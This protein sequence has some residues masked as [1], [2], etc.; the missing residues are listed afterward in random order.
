MLPVEGFSAYMALSLEP[1]NTVPLA[2][3]AGQATTGAPVLKDHRIEPSLL[4]A[5]TYA[6]VEPK[7]TEPS[8]AMAAV[9]PIAFPV[10]KVHLGAARAPTK[11]G[12]ED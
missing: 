7:Y 4:S 11:P 9:V 2:A 12:C 3:K 10:R 5:Y 8:A 1:T 6:S